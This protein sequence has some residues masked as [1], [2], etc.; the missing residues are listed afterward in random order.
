MKV[1]SLAMLL[2]T[3]QV[4]GDTPVIDRGQLL[5]DVQILSADDMQGRKVDSPGGAKARAYIVERFTQAGIRP[6]RNSYEQS[7]TFQFGK[8]DLQ[9]KGVNI[10]GLIPGTSESMIVLTAHYDHLGV[11]KEQIYNGADDNASGV[12]AL[13]AIG[14]H[15]NKHP[16]R[17]TLI[18]AALDAEERSGAG[19][20]ELAKALDK[21]NLV[22]NINMD[23]IGRDKNN[24]LYAAGTHHYPHLKPYLENVAA[25]SDVKLL[26]G[27]DRPDVKNVE[28]WTKDSDH[29]AFHRRGIPFIYFGVE[30]YE[31]HHK[32]TDDFDSLTHDFYV[33]AVQTII[34]ALEELDHFR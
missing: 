10:V 16:P 28:D 2:L 27:H 21:Q 19:G 34:M 24:I 9:H 11:R 23:M 13:F 3:L 33:G 14:A 17:N 7:F 25:K 30:D 15:F 20:E 18:V 1:V 12:A 32:H 29:Y 22:M 5:R 31:H 8:E 4:A 6:F 26:F